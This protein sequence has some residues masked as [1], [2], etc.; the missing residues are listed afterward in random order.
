MENGLTE[1][2]LVSTG[3]ALR[4]CRNS[5]SAHRQC[6]IGKDLIEYTI[7]RSPYKQGRFLPG[8]LGA[9]ALGQM[10]KDRERR[11][12]MAYWSAGLLVSNRE[13]KWKFR[14]TGSEG[15]ACIT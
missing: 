10:Q 3:T 15:R 5:P 9:L 13:A 14:F 1:E 7:D 12:L 4:P 2:R 8:T 6:G 11:Q